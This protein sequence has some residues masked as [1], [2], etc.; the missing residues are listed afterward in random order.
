[1]LLQEKTSTKLTLF[2]LDSSISVL[3]CSPWRSSTLIDMIILSCNKNF[4]G[5]SFKKTYFSALLILVAV[6]VVNPRFPMMA[7]KNGE[8][9]QANFYLQVI[10]LKR[11]PPE[12]S[13]EELFRIQV[14]TDMGK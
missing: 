2:I 14:T 4:C 11:R 13:S 8:F 5:G 9:E 3:N 10:R 1:M 6:S 12:I 7:Y